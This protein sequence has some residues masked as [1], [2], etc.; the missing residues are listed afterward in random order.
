MR[1]DSPVSRTERFPSTT[2][3]GVPSTT[4]MGVAEPPGGQT[5]LAATGGE[6]IVIDRNEKNAPIANICNAKFPFLSLKFFK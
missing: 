1:H 3:V 4:P 6:L 5:P 2:P